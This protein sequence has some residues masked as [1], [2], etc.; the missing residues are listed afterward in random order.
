ML[1]F[2]SLFLLW[3]SLHFYSSSF[4]PL[5]NPFLIYFVCIE[6]STFTHVVSNSSV[7][8]KYLEVMLIYSHFLQ[9]LSPQLRSFHFSL[10]IRV[11]IQKDQS[12][13]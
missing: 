5:Q 10:D 6:E 2:V 12:L 7:V 8:P 3:V 11:L 1:C 9:F 4:T 13:P